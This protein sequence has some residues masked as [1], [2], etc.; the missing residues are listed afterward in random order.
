MPRDEDENT[1]YYIDL[2]LEARRIIG[3]DY[4]QREHIVQYLS[5]PELHRVFVSRG[6]F[7]KLEKADLDRR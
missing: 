6:Q 3:W 5:E 1:R 2:D 4:D 7:N